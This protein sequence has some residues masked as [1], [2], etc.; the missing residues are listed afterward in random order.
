MGC[1]MNK[2]YNIETRLQC[3]DFSLN[4]KKSY[5]SWFNYPQYQ[6]CQLGDYAREY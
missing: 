2:L 6:L 3:N 5:G 4:G 1:T